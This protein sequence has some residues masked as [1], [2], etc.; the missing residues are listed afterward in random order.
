[1]S[2]E[3]KS[4]E[5]KDDILQVLR[6][7]DKSKK[8][9][10][11][12]IVKAMR[13]FINNKFLFDNWIQR[14]IYKHLTSKFIANIFVTLHLFDTFRSNNP[15]DIALNYIKWEYF[16]DTKIDFGY[17]GPDRAEVFHLQCPFGFD[18]TRNIRLCRT[19]TKLDEALVRKLGGNL[20]QVETI[21]G[22]AKKCYRIV[23]YINKE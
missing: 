11:R 10:T 1:M 8:D 15:A 16:F 12:H 19:L 7:I 2:F 18:K 9:W 13:L 6:E 23:E 14:Y 5:N 21:A 3:K 20:I 4:V 17:V 22:G